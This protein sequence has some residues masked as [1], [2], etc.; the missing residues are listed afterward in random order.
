[1][2]FPC[3]STHT[4]T[5]T[6]ALHSSKNQR[7]ENND[8]V[9]CV[10]SS[11]STKKTLGCENLFTSSETAFY[12]PRIR[13]ANSQRRS[14]A[15]EPFEPWRGRMCWAFT[16]SLNFLAIL[17]RNLVTNIIGV[18]RKYPPPVAVARTFSKNRAEENRVPLKRVR[19]QFSRAIINVVTHD[20]ACAAFFF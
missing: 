18:G 4:R 12:A 3:N 2:F 15:S 5:H 19:D 1:M 17:H 6:T 20:P 11:F 13:Y 9:S 8:N 16:H 10:V 7:K 14:R